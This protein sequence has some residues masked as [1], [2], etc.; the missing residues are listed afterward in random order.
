MLPHM[1]SN[2]P[3]RSQCLCVLSNRHNLFS[4][5]LARLCYHILPLCRSSI[6]RHG[7]FHSL[8]KSRA[9]LKNAT[10]C[11]MP[12]L[13]AKAAELAFNERVI[14]AS[15]LRER[16]IRMKYVNRTTNRIY[17]SKYISQPFLAVVYIMFAHQESCCVCESMRK[18]ETMLTPTSERS[19]SFSWPLFAMKPAKVGQQTQL[20]FI[21][22]L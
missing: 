19:C 13:S 18:Y 3:G 5:D 20:F 8:R 12:T 9:D 2:H 15:T 14:K 22:S 7:A 17:T 4:H 16:G 1:P 10:L 6:P 11:R 21:S